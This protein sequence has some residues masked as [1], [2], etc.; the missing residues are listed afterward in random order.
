MSD[1]KKGVSILH[2][3]EKAFAEVAPDTGN[4]E[5]MQEGKLDNTIGQNKDDPVMLGEEEDYITLEPSI[6]EDGDT[7]ADGLSSSYHTENI[8]TTLLGDGL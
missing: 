5:E 6:G 7:R 4:E 3:E 8:G 1:T 2:K